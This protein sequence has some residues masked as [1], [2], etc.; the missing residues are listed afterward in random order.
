MAARK[1]DYFAVFLRGAREGLE[2]TVQIFP[3]MIAL[4]TA[5]SMLNASGAAEKLAA[6]LAVPAGKLGVP[7]ELLPLILTR[8]FSGSAGTAAF[9][10]LMD[11]YGAD[12]FSAF[13]ASI[14]MGSSDTL[15]YIISVYFS[16]VPEIRRTRCAFP[17][18]IVVMLL[19]VLLSCAAARW[20]Y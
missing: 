7:G 16:A 2:N 4:V 3:A 9:S 8:P 6:M 17:A 15:V 19:C 11:T 1:K 12:S 14:L 5:L 18:A 20:F 13:C 10:A